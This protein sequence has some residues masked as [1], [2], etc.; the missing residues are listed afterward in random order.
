MSR[1]TG[2][3]GG[4][5][6]RAVIALQSRNFWTEGKVSIVVLGNPTLGDIDKIDLIIHCLGCY[7][8]ERGSRFE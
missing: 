5:E 1:A 3:K 6:E 8:E 4:N 7:R 2:V